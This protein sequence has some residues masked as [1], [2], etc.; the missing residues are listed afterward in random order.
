MPGQQQTQ[1]LRSSHLEPIRSIWGLDMRLGL[2][3]NKTLGEIAP[4]PEVISRLL[5]TVRDGSP[6]PQYDCGLI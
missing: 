4:M 3:S 6:R 2:D 5:G 1:Q